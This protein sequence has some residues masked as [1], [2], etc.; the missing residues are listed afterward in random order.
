[1]QQNTIGQ[2][3]EI[4]PIGGG[5]WI[6]ESYPTNFHH[7]WKAKMLTDKEKITDYKE[8]TNSEKT[9]LEASDAKWQKPTDT[10][11]DLWN[12]ACGTYGKYNADTGYFELNGL[13]DIS[14]AEAKAIYNAGQ[15]RGL[16]GDDFYTRRFTIRTNLPPS[17]SYSWSPIFFLLCE[18]LEVANAVGC[19][20][21]RGSFDYCRKLKRLT[22][23]IAYISGNIGF[24]LCE[25]LVDLGGLS[26]AQM[27]IPTNRT[28]PKPP[29]EVDLQYS[30]LLT[31]SS[32]SKFFKTARENLYVSI[33][34]PQ[35]I[36]DKITD[37]TNQEWHALLDVASSKNITLLT[38]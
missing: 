12:E 29:Y 21:Y 19:R 4:Q 37:V 34:L 26:M 38:P 32:L 20:P 6:T 31:S 9:Q 28:N 10:F 5:N 22:P 25:K 7:F 35:E 2:V 1:M 15:I 16:G 18:Q 13:T 27:N 30:P 11:V 17:G 24:Y 3:T 23:D 8:V 33:K 36:Y 14:L